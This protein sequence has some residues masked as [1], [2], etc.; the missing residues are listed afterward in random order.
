MPDLPTG[1]KSVRCQHC[2]RQYAT[3]KEWFDHLDMCDKEQKEPKVEIELK[4]EDR[5]TDFLKFWHP[6]PE[7]ESCWSLLC[8][9]WYWL[10]PFLI[11]ALASGALGFYWGQLSE[12]TMGQ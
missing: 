9:V 3:Q 5:A 6:E 4:V 1:I 2:S 8:E 11:T 12:R 10:W 7:E